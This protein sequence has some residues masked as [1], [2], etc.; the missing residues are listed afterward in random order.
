MIGPTEAP[1]IVEDDVRSTETL[2]VSLFAS[3]Q[4]IGVVVNFNNR[5]VEVTPGSPAEAAGF[6]PFDL[7]VA[8][9]GKPCAGVAIATLVDAESTT[10]TFEVER[11]AKSERMGIC[12]AENELQD[13]FKAQQDQ[14]AAKRSKAL[15]AEEMRMKMLER[16]KSKLAQVEQEAE[17]QQRRSAAQPVVSG[18]EGRQSTAR[19]LRESRRSLQM[20]RKL[21]AEISRLEVDEREEVYE[22]QV[23]GELLKPALPS[24]SGG[25][26]VGGSGGGSGGAGAFAS[27]RRRSMPLMEKSE[28]TLGAMQDQAAAARRALDERRSAAVASNR[29]ASRPPTTPIPLFSEVLAE[30]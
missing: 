19:A 18:P 27:S 12:E 1:L 11:P 4:S 20:T 5:V 26:G 10:L 23:N 17:L 21:E 16:R 2:T 7:I 15:A 13:Y 30:G 9:D 29:R 25:S 8:L 3:G 28:T 24:G 6:R 14:E 22:L